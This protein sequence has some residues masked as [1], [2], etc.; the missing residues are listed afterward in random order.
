[1]VGCEKKQHVYCGV[2]VY[3]E[4]VDAC[5]GPVGENVVKL[6]YAHPVLFVAVCCVV[7]HPVRSDDVELRVCANDDR[8]DHCE[9]SAPTTTEGPE[10]IGIRRPRNRNEVAI[11][12]DNQERNDVV[13]CHPVTAGEW[14]LSSS[15]DH[16]A[17][18]A[19]ALITI[20]DHGDQRCNNRIHLTQRPLQAQ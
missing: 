13:C 16:P 15:R 17:C 6:L 11:G 1:M 9:R 8:D 10:K 2:R 14:I 3:I 19:Y 7:E 4:R 20:R 18:I 5:V 12:G